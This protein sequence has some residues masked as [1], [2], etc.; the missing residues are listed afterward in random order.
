MLYL[1]DENVLREMR[2]GGS[3]NVRRWLAIVNET[4]RA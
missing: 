4:E 1:L 2:G 3:A